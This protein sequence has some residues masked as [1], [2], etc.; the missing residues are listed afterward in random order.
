MVS[1]V[2]GTQ[3]EAE[4][5]ET[6]PVLPGIPIAPRVTDTDLGPVEF[7]LT[8]GDGPVVLGSGGVG[9]VR[10]ARLQLEWLDPGRYRLL[11]VSRPGFLGTPLSSGPGVEAQADLFVAL[12]DRLQI[13]RAAVVSLSAGGPAG[14][15]LALRHPERVA[16]MIAI[17]SV[18]GRHHVP[19]SA[20]PV[21]QTIF[22]NSWTQGLFGTLARRRPG[23]MLR[24]VL[25]DTGY[26]TKSQLR[27]HLEF[28]LAT[29]EA[30][31]FGRALLGTFFPYGPSK[32]GADNDTALFRALPRLPLEHVRCPVLVVHGT[33]D[34]DVKF[35][36]GVYA[37]EQIPGAE[38]VWIEEGSHVG[39]WLSPHARAAQEAA[40]A[41]LER[42]RPW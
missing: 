26:Y 14:Y 28:T 38:R 13:E 11:S 35:H 19:E 32:A 15:L 7:D 24:Q 9:G 37:F 29:P 33:H 17:D 2:V 12:L 18:S 41:F 8:P 40:R 39:F 4:R 16:A 5:T 30:L 6:R 22:M 36:H 3:I 23:W 27:A 10:G 1:E 31:A 21:A 34:A 42:Q 25:R 20:G